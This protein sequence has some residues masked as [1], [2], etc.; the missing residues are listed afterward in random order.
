VFGNWAVISANAPESA[1][2]FGLPGA[3]LFP[4]ND[5]GNKARFEPQISISVR[6]AARGPPISA[7]RQMNGF[8]RMRPRRDVGHDPDY[9][10]TL[11]NERTLLA[12]IR[13]SL[14]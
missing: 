8:P 12:W 3:R 9:R 6:K 10:L 2:R 5:T 13:T 14:A 7:C 11:A 1:G 4:F